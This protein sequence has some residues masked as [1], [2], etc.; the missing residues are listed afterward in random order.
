MPKETFTMSDFS[1]G[2][3]ENADT[4]DLL[5]AKQVPSCQDVN[6]EVQGKISYSTTTSFSDGE[7]STATPGNSITNAANKLDATIGDAGESTASNALKVKIEAV[8]SSSDDL[9]WED[10]LYDFKY[11]VC[12]DLG[13]GFIEEGPL[14]SFYETGAYDATAVNMSTDDLGKFTF[15]HAGHSSNHPDHMVDAYNDS[16]CGRVY[17][18]R[19]SGQG[20]STQAGW[21]HLCDLIL[22]DHNVADSVFPRAVGLSGTAGLSNVIDIEE[23]PT[24]AS[25]EMNAGYPSDVG[26]ITTTSGTTINSI[27]TI[28]ARVFLGLVKYFASTKG[29]NFYI[30][31][32]LPGQPDVFPTDGWIDMTTYGACLAMFGLG[33]NLVY[34]TAQSGTNKMIVF[35]VTKDTVVYE[36]D[37]YGTSDAL[38]ARKLEDGIAFV[39]KES[40]MFFNGQKVSNL[41]R[42][43][44]KDSIGAAISLEYNS[45]DRSILCGAGYPMPLF[46]FNTNTWTRLTGTPTSLYGVVTLPTFHFGEPGRFKKIYKI[47]V[48]LDDEDNE[49]APTIEVK[50]EFNDVQ[51]FS[52]VTSTHTGDFAPDSSYKVRELK[53]T[54]S[55]IRDGNPLKAV[56]IVYRK[57][58]KF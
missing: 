22:D 13:N 53:I 33:N 43:R 1:G 6:F 51:A 56:S 37:G 14:Q 34:F 45:Q 49:T 9:S 2:M 8:T 40:L 32:S 54:I 5:E 15:E 11:S 25:Y 36:G 7:L 48:H 35:D 57:L 47:I 27:G 52:A 55:N 17:Y 41:S 50:N 16:L 46:Y 28:T 21:I 20:S 38:A 58:N 39:S 19:Q 12:I 42:P 44:M 24:S 18:S 31:R 30:Y 23:P 26:I 3:N 10:G 4:L 29:S